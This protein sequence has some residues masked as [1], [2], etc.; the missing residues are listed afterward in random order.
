MLRALGAFL[1]VATSL[2]AADPVSEAAQRVQAAHRVFEQVMA[3]PDKAIPADLLERAHCVAVIPALKKGGFIVG[4]RYGVGV[5]LCRDE[6]RLGWTGPSTVRVEGGSVGFQIGGGEVDL[7][8]LVMNESGV[9][10]LIKS[11]F[12]I[13]GEVGV[14]AGPVGRSAHAQTD[15]LLEAEILSYSR[16][17]GLFAGVAIEGSTLRADEED[18]RELYGKPVTH[19]E[20]LEGKVEPPEVASGLI[21]TLNR[22]SPKEQK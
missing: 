21:S 13:G 8:L 4:G 5:A 7:I 17:K 14:M 1:L 6:S 18:N 12:T 16:S 20:I 22:Y 3:I 10:E 15:A 19:R 2:T 9:N 11:E